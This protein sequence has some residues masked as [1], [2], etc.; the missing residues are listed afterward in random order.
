MLVCCWGWGGGLLGGLGWSSNF[1]EFRRAR[2]VS[3]GFWPMGGSNQFWYFKVPVSPWLLHPLM[4]CCL[5]ISLILHF[6]HYKLMIYRR[7]WVFH[8]SH[9]DMQDN[10]E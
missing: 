1:W 9:Q 10:V 7:P 5:A 8:F 4:D 2:R 6:N 3:G